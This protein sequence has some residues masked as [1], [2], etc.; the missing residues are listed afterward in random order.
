MS[1]VSHIIIAYEILISY[2]IIHMDFKLN[3][4]DHLVS[5]LDFDLILDLRAKPQMRAKPVK[6]CRLY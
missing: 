1:P 5:W 6:H 4:S 2:S 3:F